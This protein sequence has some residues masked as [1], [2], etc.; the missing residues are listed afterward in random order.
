MRFFAVAALLYYYGEPIRGF[1]ERYLGP[2]FVLF[3]V[4]LFA[5]FVVLKYLA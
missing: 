1:I 5:G 4:L 3:V 2:L